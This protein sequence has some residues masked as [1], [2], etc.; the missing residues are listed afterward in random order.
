[1]KNWLLCTACGL[2]WLNKRETLLWLIS[3][4]SRSKVLIWLKIS[5]K[6]TATAKYVSKHYYYIIRGRNA[7]KL[8]MLLQ[9]CMRLKIYLLWMLEDTDLL[10][11]SIIDRHRV[12]KMQLHLRIAGACLKTCG[13]NGLTRSFFFWQKEHRW[14]E[15]DIMRY[16]GAV[17]YTHLDVYKRQVL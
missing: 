13:R 10:S 3:S 5:A 4:L 1:M 8:Q 12:L 17:S 14:Q 16:S 11:Y 15:W 9:S 6:K 7:E 2:I